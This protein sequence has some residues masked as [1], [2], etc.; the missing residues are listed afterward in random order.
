MYLVMGYNR[1]Q[2]MALL[3][4]GDPHLGLV[5]SASYVASIDLAKA[6]AG[7]IVLCALKFANGSIVALCV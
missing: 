4:T 5:H 3:K 6:H 2:Q 1:R 7:T